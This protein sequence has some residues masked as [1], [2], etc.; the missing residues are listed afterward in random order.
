MSTP[1]TFLEIAS[2]HYD[3]LRAYAHQLSRDYDDAEDALQDCLIKCATAWPSYRPLDDESVRRYLGAAIRNRLR[4]KKQKRKVYIK[5]VNALAQ[6]EKPIA[7]M[8]PIASAEARLQAARDRDDANC[9]LI[10]DVLV[11]ARKELPDLTVRCFELY[12][13][14]Y[15]RQQTAELLGVS[16]AR[17]HRCVVAAKAWVT[18]RFGKRYVALQST[19]D[20]LDPFGV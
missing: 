18:K 3:E 7:P 4:P 10:R 8:E 6:W 11:E 9:D 16:P 19:D 17:A 1:H 12:L 15:T 20:D 5:D 13:S 2:R 14:A